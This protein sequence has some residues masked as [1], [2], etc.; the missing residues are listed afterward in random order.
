MDIIDLK[1]SIDKKIKKLEEI[2]SVIKERGE[3]KALCLSE[4]EKSLA[5]TIIK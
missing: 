2:R 5:V 3:E 1:Q 4:Y